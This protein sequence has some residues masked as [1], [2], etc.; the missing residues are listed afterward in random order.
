MSILAGGCFSP[1][2][3]VAPVSDFDLDR[4]LGKWYEIARLDH[5]FERGLS[6]V[7]AEYSLRDHGDILVVNRG[8]DELRDEWSEAR[9]V[10]RPIGPPDLASLKVAFFWPF[11]GAYH[12]IA[13]DADYR[14]AM[15]TSSTRDYLWILSRRPRLDPAV[16][17]DLLDQAA[18]QGFATERLIFVEHE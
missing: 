14:W 15:V 9:G 3:G 8:Y 12:V 2:R 16:L 10:A 6:R 4:Y 17:D 11:W 18:R 13:L 5:S 1:P 7:T